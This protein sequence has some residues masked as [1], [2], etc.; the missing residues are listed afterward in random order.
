MLHAPTQ[1]FCTKALYNLAVR[2]FLCEELFEALLFLHQSSRERQSGWAAGFH[3]NV[4]SRIRICI[5]RY[6]HFTSVSCQCFRRVVS[7]RALHI[8]SVG[9]SIRQALLRCPSCCFTVDFS[10]LDFPPL[11]FNTAVHS[12]PPDCS[13]R[14]YL[15]ANKT[16]PVASDMP[17]HD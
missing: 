6:Y 13:T 2:T 3:F 7:R 10:P 5:W 8:P 4:S 9:G 17:A 11:S 12:G 15:P 1:L 16:V 14:V